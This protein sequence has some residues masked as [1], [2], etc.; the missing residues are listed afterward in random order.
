MSLE[1][2]LFDIGRARDRATVEKLVTD[3]RCDDSL[4]TDEKETISEIGAAHIRKFL[5]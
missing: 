4:H 2:Y 1:I 3:A 5:S